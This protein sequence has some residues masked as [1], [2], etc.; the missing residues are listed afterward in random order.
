VKPQPDRAPAFGDTV[1]LSPEA[2]ATYPVLA[3]TDT[4]LLA[5]WATG[6]DQSQVKVRSIPLP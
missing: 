5:V 1:V 6:G 2:P 3:A 4:R